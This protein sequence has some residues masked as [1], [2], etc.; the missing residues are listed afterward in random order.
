MALGVEA[1]VV[2]PFMENTYLVCDDVLGEALLVDPGCEAEPIARWLNEHGLRAVGIVN[3]HAHID[4]VA[5]VAQARRHFGVPF[6]IHAREKVLVQALPVQARMFGMEPPEAL[7]VDRWLAEGDEVRVGAHVARVIHT[8]GHSPGGICLFFAGERRLLTGDTLFVGSVGRTDYPGGDSKKL[9]M[10]IRERL[11][12]L[13]DDVLFYPGH[14]PSGTL[15][16]ER[17]TNPF[18]GGAAHAR[19]SPTS[20]AG[21]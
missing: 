18:V 11:F 13:G 8:P 19:G 4:H 7:E 2:P 15:G 17:R 5:G 9:L 21:A 16:D 10:S 12:T 20:H 1:L 6:A 3:T 14:G